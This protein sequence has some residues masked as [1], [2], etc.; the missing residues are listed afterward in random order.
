MLLRF[1]LLLLTN[2]SNCFVLKHNTLKS[3]NKRTS[4]VNMV[5]PNEIIDLSENPEKVSL[6][7]EE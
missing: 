2:L 5:T 3:L 6:L 7:F 4:I 1:T